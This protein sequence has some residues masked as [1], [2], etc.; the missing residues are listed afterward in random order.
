MFYI[1]IVSFKF[2]CL[3]A[4]LQSSRSFCLIGSNEIMRHLN[5]HLSLLTVMEGEVAVTGFFCCIE[6][7]GMIMLIIGVYAFRD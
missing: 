7:E 2:P 6:K 1:S 5:V 3:A 4:N